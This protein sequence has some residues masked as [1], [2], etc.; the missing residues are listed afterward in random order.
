V[1]LTAVIASVLP[2]GFVSVIFSVAAPLT[3]IVGGLNVCATT[4]AACGCAV[5]V[6]CMTPVALMPA[7]ALPLVTEPVVF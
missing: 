3:A 7:S 6:L 2:G 5:L 1:K 4:G